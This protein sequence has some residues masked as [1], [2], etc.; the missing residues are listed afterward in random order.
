M[1]LWVNYGILHRS[2]KWLLLSLPMQAVLRLSG[3][4]QV[5]LQLL[6]TQFRLIALLDGLVATQVGLL[7][8]LSLSFLI[9]LITRKLN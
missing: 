9:E 3:L 6:W 2:H 7:C 8:D 1:H 4:L 5:L